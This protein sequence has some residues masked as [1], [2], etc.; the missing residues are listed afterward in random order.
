MRLTALLALALMLTLG[1]APAVSEQEVTPAQIEDLKERIED[2]D[3][4][5][6]D[7]EDDRS[8][9]ERQLAATER[10]ISRLT[11][12]RRTLREQVKTQQRRLNELQ[13]EER[14]LT[15]TLEQQRE[16]L[17]QQ[18]RTAWMEGDAPAV[19]VLLNEINPDNIARTM[20]YYEYLSRDTVGRLEDF[21]KN[22][23]ELKA[24]QAAAQNTRAELAKTEEGVIERQ[25]KLQ[26]SREEREQTL[27][28]LEQDIRSRRNEKV[29]LE[30]DRK[31][32]EN[33]LSEVQQAIANIPSP[34]ESQPFS[35][36]RN[37]LPWPAQGKVTSGFGD[38][39]ADGKLRRNGLII[40][41]NED[42]EVKA[43][44]Y[45][46]V[47]FANWLR[48]FGLI[49]IIDHGDGYMTLYGH[50]SS[51]F[52]SPGDWVAAGEAIALAGRTGGTDNPALYFEVRHNGK[53]DNPGRWLGK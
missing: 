22:L 52:T 15:R 5:L 30:S 26:A 21:R 9:L 23:Q 24:T 28:A 12:E 50:S 43:I 25:K 38:K 48:G 44:H 49:T 19:K 39:Y 41:T 31:R 27:A 8:S 45:G 7:A 34:N 4:W 3:D 17:K 42:A 16:S 32:L 14:E 51:L 33:L 36:L 20:T 1:A 10:T 47:V 35:S 37:K 11:R 46:R 53:P 29:E 2:I 40:Q 18:I 6:A 13:G